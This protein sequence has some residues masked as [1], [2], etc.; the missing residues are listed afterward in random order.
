MTALVGLGLGVGLGTLIS[1]L[2]PA[3]ASIATAVLWLGMLVPIVWALSRS[4]PVGFLRFRPLDLLWGAGLG[5]GLRI[6]QGSLAPAFGGSAA[7]PSYPTI[8]GS[9][10]AGFLFSEAIAPV[11]IAPALEEF[12]FRGVVLVSLYTVLRRPVG[13]VIAGAAA[14]I[15]STG[16]FVLAHS[17]NGLMTAD[18]VLSLSLLGLVCG[19]L[20]ILTGRIW[21]AV[22]VHIVYN[23][24]FVVL[25][26]AGTYL[27]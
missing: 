11:L 4:R 25:A 1:L 27:A 15:G 10:P 18:A 6:V 23:A 8:D 12:F 24:S 9:L 26:L 7:L 16:L 2:L 21:G 20:V 13:A 22:L 19:T 5:L 14:V 17:V 3:Q